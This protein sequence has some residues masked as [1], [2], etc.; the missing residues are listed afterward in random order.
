MSALPTA[1]R[2]VSAHPSPD[3]YAP[4]KPSPLTPSVTS[5]T[6]AAVKEHDIENKMKLYGIVEAVRVPPC[7][8]PR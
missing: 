4:P 8:R 3:A 7:A 6:D 1:K 2:E 5:P